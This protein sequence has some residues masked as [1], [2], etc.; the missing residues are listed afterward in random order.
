MNELSGKHSRDSST[1]VFGGICLVLLCYSLTAIAG[2][3]Q[4]GR[5]LLVEKQAAHADHS[6]S[7]SNESESSSNLSTI[8]PPPIFTII[9][10][11]LLLSAIAI[12]PLLHRV[13]HWWEHN[14]SKLFIATTLGMTTLSYY[15][16][17]HRDAVEIHFPCHGLAQASDYGPSWS[18]VSAVLVNA[19][20]SEYI[21]FIV[22]LFSLFVIA[23][24]VRIEGDLVASS[25]T[26]TLFLL[27]GALAASFI[28]TTGAAM[29]LIRPLLETNRERKHVAH[30]VVFFIF[31]VCNCGGCLL[32]VGDPPLFLGYLEGVDFFWT[33]SLWKE[34]LV[35]N[36]LIITIYWLWDSLVELPKETQLDLSRD[37]GRTRQ[38]VIRGLL[39][40]PLMIGVIAS[41]ALLDPS[42][43]FPG[44][45]W[46]PW[47]FLREVVLLSLV[48]IS[49]RCGDV[50][51]RRDNG[52]NY[53][54]IIEVAVLFLGIFICMQP[55][56]SIL[57]IYGPT[58]G[59]SSSRSFFWATG[60]L[61]SVLDNAPTYLV[62]FKTAQSLGTEAP[63][64]AGVDIGRLAGVSLGAVFL[65][66]MTYIGNGPN[67]MVKAIAE[68]QGIRM[69]SFFGYMVWSF[70]VLLPVFAFISFL[71]L[72]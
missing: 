3:P 64:M 9:P 67:F 37:R 21:P 55:A 54:A 36:L 42:K 48:G 39:S 69:P 49:L 47:I 43:V 40:V 62:F 7:H 57:Q 19:L 20:L 15:L 18:V 26:N 61:S 44:T 51:I 13:E 52:F 17:F 4:H 2:W 65:G 14:L 1:L 23:G 38:M 50:T 35:T 12:L 25:T 22:L 71:F 70:C 24:S 53:G 27:V 30:T 66:A 6:H 60:L 11:V 16:F 33:L 46:H 31:V 32:P 29:V 5:D 34:W 68:K 72:S 8:I 28:G 10:F 58:L 45:D 41:V 59:L 56:L 63:T